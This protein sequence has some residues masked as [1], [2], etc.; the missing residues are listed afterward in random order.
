[1]SG[2]WASALIAWFM[3]PPSLIS[4]LMPGTGP[5]REF[6]AL[7]FFIAAMVLSWR[8]TN[9]AIGKGP[10]LATGVFAG[11]FIVS[12]IVLFVMQGWLGLNL[13]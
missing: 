4:L 13:D 11:M 1:M 7:L 8:V 12:V 9:V 5:V 2:N 3:L 6:V 10:A